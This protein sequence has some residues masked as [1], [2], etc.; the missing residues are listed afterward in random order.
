[1]PQLVSMLAASSETSKKQAEVFLKTY[2]AVIA[3]ALESHDTIKIKDFGTFKVNRVEARKSVNVSTGDE[4]RIPSHYKVVFTP[5]KS[6]ADKVNSE[7]AW[8]EI[9]EISDDVKD[10]ILEKDS[11]DLL[12]DTIPMPSE[13]L[14]GTKENPE[15]KGVPD[16]L[17]EG[18]L[19]ETAD[20]PEFPRTM[21]EISE[22]E[23]AEENETILEIQPPLF[24]ADIP[25][26]LGSEINDVKCIT[27]EEE[28][29]S[30][31]LGEELE[32]DFGDIEPVEPFG[33]VDPQ[34]PEP[35]EPIPED[36]SDSGSPIIPE[37]ALLPEIPLP[38][39]LLEETVVNEKNLVSESG[40]AVR[41]EATMSPGS[42]D[43]DPYAL[44]KVTP[45][46]TEESPVNTDYATKE[47]ISNLATKAEFRLIGRNVKKIKV[48][49]EE[50]E[51][52]T[53]ERSR[54]TVIWCLIL[55]AALLTGGFFLTYWLLL[56][57]ISG[58]MNVAAENIEETIEEE[59]EEGIDSSIS[60]KGKTTT[61][62]ET[63]EEQPE[64]NNEAVPTASEESLTTTAP[65]SPSDIKALDKVTN[66]RYL[67]TMAK[68]HYGNYNFWPYIYLE[69][70][71][72]L[73]H[74]DRIRPGTQVVIPNIEKYHIDPS[75][76]KDIDKA[77]KLGVEIYKKYAHN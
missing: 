35:G 55:C 31:R 64:T 38:E 17:H 59:L 7:F 67:T 14:E 8:L 22:E 37:V 68:E 5:S 36:L 1:M 74:P 30:E 52:S 28:Q 12:L 71:G 63:I 46:R 33:P 2:F 26:A 9:V 54:K 57:R 24:V 47:E 72:K 10:E 39:G 23:S 25:A 34:D 48:S 3:E 6:M 75:N 16:E 77:K 19:E 41:E 4:V 13:N 66:T 44:D 51:T 27:R 20:I 18:T 15:T 42:K 60:I 69:N 62:E 61:P 70:E 29:Q 11:P 73:G 76:P 49:L 40:E 32:K 56:N 58:M 43:F 65:T 53:R 45:Q 21:P 50:L